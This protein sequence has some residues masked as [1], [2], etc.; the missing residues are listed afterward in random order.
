MPSPELPAVDTPASKKTMA[1][2]APNAAPC[3]T[4]KVDDEARGLRS[5]FCMTH[6]ARLNVAPTTTAAV[7]LGKRIEKRIVRVAASA[8]SVSVVS[9]SLNVTPVAPEQSDN[10]TAAIST[11]ASQTSRQAKVATCRR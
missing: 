3:E 8:L 7:S 10:R 4:P 5:T 9:R 2:A 6:P 11:S 1:K